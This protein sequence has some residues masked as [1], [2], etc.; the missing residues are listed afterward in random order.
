MSIS[1]TGV[2]SSNLWYQIDQAWNQSRAAISQQFLDESSV[3]NSALTNAMSNQI[4][5][6]ATL[7]AQAALKRIQGKTATAN[8]TTSSTAT[9]ATTGAA[10]SATAS[11]SSSSTSPYIYTSAA[12]ILSSSNVVNFFA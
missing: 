7:A 4:S 10:Q 9:T 12:S 5:G 2:A 8:G 6:T 11:N 3:L 1:G